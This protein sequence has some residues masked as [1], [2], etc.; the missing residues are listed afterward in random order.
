M[1]SS[2][3]KQA[4]YLSLLEIS[5]FF[6]VLDHKPLEGVWVAHFCD[7]DLL[8]ILSIGRRYGKNLELE[9]NG[10]RRRMQMFTA[11]NSPRGVPL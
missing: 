4:H 7:V 11:V 3:I 8:G 10:K 2:I 1:T 6:L 9:R 5:P